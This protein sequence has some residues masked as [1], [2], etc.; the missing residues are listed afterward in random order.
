MTYRRATASDAKPKS[1][2]T[3]PLSPLLDHRLAAY[4]L[5]A[6]VAGVSTTALAQA[7]Q[8]NNIQYTPANIPFN[9]GTRGHQTRTID[10]D[11]NSDGITDVKFIGDSGGFAVSGSRNSSYYS[12]YGI[13]YWLAPDGGIKRPLASGI[14]ISPVRTFVNEGQLATVKT[15]KPR[16]GHPRSGCEG[17]FNNRSAY[18]GLRFVISGETHYGWVRVSFNCEPNSISGTISGYAY[19]IVPNAGLEA[20]Q[21]QSGKP[22]KP[23]GKDSGT[24]GSLSL[25]SERQQ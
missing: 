4:A 13:G 21:T 19:N 1:R 7:P 18:F 6:G 14:E 23:P 8:E 17:P 12:Y 2:K 15:Q 5:V 25:G 24:L 22:I 10:L 20:G 3:K 11:L 16:R 9:Y